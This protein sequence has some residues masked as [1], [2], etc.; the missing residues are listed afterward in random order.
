VQED[1][2]Y[3]PDELNALQIS[4]KLSLYDFVPIA[5]D[6][7]ASNLYNLLFVKNSCL[8]KCS[9]EISN[10]WINYANLIIPFVRLRSLRDLFSL[11]KKN[12]VTANLSARPSITD[13]LFSVAGSK[14]SKQ[15]IDD[16]NSS[17]L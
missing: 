2:A 5:R 7:P 1:Q 6:Y 16:W 11:L 15:K 12:L 3:Y 10:F 4:D 17:Q 13:H 14:S 8:D 9:T